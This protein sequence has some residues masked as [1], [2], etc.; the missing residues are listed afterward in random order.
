MTDRVDRLEMILDY[1]FPDRDPVLEALALPGSRSSQCMEGNKRQAII[2]DG[3][4]AL[5]LG[6]DWYASGESRSTSL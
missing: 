2:G 4:I 1:V 5:V 6:E 3:L